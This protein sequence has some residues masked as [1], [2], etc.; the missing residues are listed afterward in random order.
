MDSAKTGRERRILPRAI[1]SAEE[2]LTAVA[3][4]TS[5]EAHQMALKVMNISRGGLGLAIHRDQV[6]GIYSGDRLILNSLTI[7]VTDKMVPCMM[8]M[9]VAWILDHKYLDNVG[10]G[11]K[12]LGN[13]QTAIEDIVTFIN[14]TFPNRMV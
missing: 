8:D 2:N 5:D 4:S 3:R 12:F 13:N 14:E 9:E 1:F 7:G 6:N 11:C 10:I